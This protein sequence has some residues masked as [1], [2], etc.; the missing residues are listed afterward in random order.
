MPEDIHDFLKGGA[1]EDTFPFVIRVLLDCSDVKSCRGN[2]KFGSKSLQVRLK[3]IKYG[4]LQFSQICSIVVPGQDK[5]PICII[6]NSD[7]A[8]ILLDIPEV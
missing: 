4:F 1:D 5:T 3:I 8:Y 2:G 6:E 7:S